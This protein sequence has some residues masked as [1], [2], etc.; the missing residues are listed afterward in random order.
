VKRGVARAAS[1]AAASAPCSRKAARSPCRLP[2]AVTGRRP[3]TQKLGPCGRPKPA[4]A[5]PS[6]G[7]FF[8][9]KVSRLERGRH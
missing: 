8:C 5:A 4:I 7:P 2:R 3:D 1:E 9:A 6:A